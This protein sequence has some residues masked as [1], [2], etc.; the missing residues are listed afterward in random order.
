MWRL[1][2]AQRFLKCTNSQVISGRFKPL[3]FITLCLVCLQIVWSVALKISGCWPRIGSLF[4][5]PKCIVPS[6]QG[7]IQRA[8]AGTHSCTCSWHTA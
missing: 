8:L 7:I 6:L 1:L 4:S 5:D 3:W 2:L